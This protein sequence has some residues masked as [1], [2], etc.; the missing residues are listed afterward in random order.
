MKL[1]TFTKDIN[2]D[3]YA[4]ILGLKLYYESFEAAGT[5]FLICF[6]FLVMGVEYI[7]LKQPLNIITIFVCFSGLTLTSAIMIKGHLRCGLILYTIYHVYQILFAIVLTYYY[8]TKQLE[9]DYVITM[10]NR[11]MDTFLDYISLILESKIHFLFIY[12]LCRL[13]IIIGFIDFTVFKL[14]TT[15]IL[16]KPDIGGIEVRHTY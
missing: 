11:N 10:K 15:W 5:L 1:I 16:P 8:F 7:Y 6:E 3:V 13:L 2:N 9:G 14:T 12:V 4:K